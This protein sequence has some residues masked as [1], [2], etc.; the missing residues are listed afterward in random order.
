MRA[1]CQ[2]LKH[3]TGPRQVLQPRASTLC[4]ALSSPLLLGQGTSS[5]HTIIVQMRRHD[6]NMMKAAYEKTEVQCDEDDGAVTFHNDDDFDH[7]GDDANN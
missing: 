1:R 5:R 7:E 6:A 4:L 2:A 3:R